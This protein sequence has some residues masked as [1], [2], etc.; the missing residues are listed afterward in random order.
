MRRIAVITPVARGPH[1]LHVS[2]AVAST[3]AFPLHV[4]VYDGAQQSPPAPQFEDERDRVAVIT[5]DDPVGRS[6]ARN[7]GIRAAD[8]AGFEWCLFIDADDLMLPTAWADLQDAKEADLYYGE[9][10]F[11]DG[12]G[13]YNHVPFDADTRAKLLEAPT[14]AKLIVPN[15]SYAV[16]TERALR[17]LFDP[18]ISHGEHFD[19]FIKYVANPSIRVHML[20]RPLITVRRSLSTAQFGP[21]QDGSRERYQEWQTA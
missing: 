16:R 18:M 11:E 12:S 7:I 3:T 8:A 19:F 21:W 14:R 6:E 4:V 9:H 13:S 17:V 10:F 1:R 5:T 2:D 20:R 15:V